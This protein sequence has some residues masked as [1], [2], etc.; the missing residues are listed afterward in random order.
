VT[1]GVDEDCRPKASRRPRAERVSS[2]A[3][4]YTRPAE[5][6]RESVRLCQH[7]HCTDVQAGPRISQASPVGAHQQTPGPIALMQFHRR[8]ASLDAASPVVMFQ[9]GNQAGQLSQ[10]IDS[11]QSP[12]DS[13]W[14]RCC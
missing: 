4:S 6:H 3:S 12:S 8:A 14:W 1:L 7:Q 11:G 5:P 10:G 2:L 9:G 13:V